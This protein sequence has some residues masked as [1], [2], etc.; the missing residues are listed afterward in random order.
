MLTLHWVSQ[1][2]GLGNHF[3]LCLSY[4]SIIISCFNVSIII[5]V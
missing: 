2:F 3:S 5:S 4:V 1:K